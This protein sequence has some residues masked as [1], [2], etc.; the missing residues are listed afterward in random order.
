MLRT[1]ALAAT[2]ALV[3]PGLAAAQDHRDEHHQGGPPPH[4]GGPPAHPAGP[5]PGFAPHGPPPSGAM[6][7]P[8]PPGPPAAMIRPPDR[9]VEHPM[10]HPVAGPVERSVERPIERHMEGP[11]EHRMGPPPGDAARFNYRDREVERVH[12][13]PFIYP[14][15]YGYRRWDVGAALPPVFLLQDYWYGDWDAL[16]LDPPPPGYEWVRYGPDLL[17]VDVTTAQVAEVAYDVFYE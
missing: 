16:G 5:P 13:R 12:I 10:E 2:I 11:M 14:P 9:P 4:P 6:M 3:T 8:H 15:G 7:A 1:L 17:L